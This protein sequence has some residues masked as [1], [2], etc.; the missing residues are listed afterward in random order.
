MR[1]AAKKNGPLFFVFPDA[2]TSSWGG[3]EAEVEHG[4]TP[5]VRLTSLWG[6]GVIS[7][8]EPPSGKMALG[9]NDAWFW[10]EVF[11]GIHW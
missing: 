9:R 4:V 3:E 6:H 2:R 11:L 7:L 8:Y 1:S 5:T 10:Q